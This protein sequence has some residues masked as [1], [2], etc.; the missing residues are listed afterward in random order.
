[1]ASDL[2]V[3]LDWISADSAPEGIGE[4]TRLQEALNSLPDGFRLAVVM[5]YFEQCSYREIAEQLDVPLGT[6]MS[7]L[8][9]AKEQLRRILS[10][11][12]AGVPHEG[13]AQRPRKD[14]T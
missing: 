14:I 4:E 1:M 6:V 12:T 10:E 7:R 9:R 8:A 13:A 3:R 2:N 11:P 5:F